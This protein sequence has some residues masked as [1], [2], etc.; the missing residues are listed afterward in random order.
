M[1]IR[2]SLLA[3][4]FLGVSSMTSAQTMTPLPFGEED[5]FPDLYFPA[6]EDGR[7]VSI[8]DFLGK[9]LILQVFASW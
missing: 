2:I 5:R 8:D 7:A 3:F 9:K 1:S 4:L 6:L